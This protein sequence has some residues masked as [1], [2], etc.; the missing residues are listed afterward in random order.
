MSRG[1]RQ[2][3]HNALLTASS[4]LHYTSSMPRQYPPLNY[5]TAMQVRVSRE[6]YALFGKVAKA[7][8][9]TLSSWAR[10]RLIQAAKRDL[11][12]K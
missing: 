4:F 2:P 8:G 10:E 12:S 5:S 3:R 11:P 6:Q 1:N 7:S 9:L